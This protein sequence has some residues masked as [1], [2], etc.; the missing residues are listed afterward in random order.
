MIIELC[1]IIRQRLFDS[2]KHL[3]E[4]LKVFIQNFQLTPF[5]DFPDK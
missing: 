1:L 4:C 3:Q 5:N 2:N